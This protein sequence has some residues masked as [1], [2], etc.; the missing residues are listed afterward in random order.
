MVCLPGLA[1][2]NQCLNVL[3]IK[4]APVVTD[5][6]D[7]TKWIESGQNGFVVPVKRPDL[8]AEKIVYLLK[9][10]EFRQKV[11]KANFQLVEQRAIYEKEMGK[12]VK[13]YEELVKQKKDF[14]I[15]PAM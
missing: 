13:L 11:G 2:L 3:L 10:K 5:V 1:F 14:D 8:L 12:M 6:G 4:I 9:N 7:N 15:V